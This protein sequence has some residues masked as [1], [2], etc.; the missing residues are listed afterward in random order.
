MPNE[1]KKK[2][3]LCSWVLCAEID[4]DPCV[5]HIIYSRVEG[6]ELVGGGHLEGD[7]QVAVSSHAWLPHFGS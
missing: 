3:A 5:Y 1:T 7:D 4:L 6:D 2:C